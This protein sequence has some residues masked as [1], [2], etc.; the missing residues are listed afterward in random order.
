MGGKY[1][2]QYIVYRLGIISAGVA[3]GRKLMRWKE[4]GPEGSGAGKGVMPAER[5]GSSGICQR[6]VMGMV[7]RLSCESR[8]SASFTNLMPFLKL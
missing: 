4:L 6:L 8:A 5:R 1:F 2:I 7:G 3:R